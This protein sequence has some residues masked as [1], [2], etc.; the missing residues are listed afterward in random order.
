MERTILH[1]DMNNFYATVE[2]LYHP[3]WQGKPIAVGGSAERRH[4]V[5]LAKSEAAK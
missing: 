1:V 2:C 5:V 4:G 3:E